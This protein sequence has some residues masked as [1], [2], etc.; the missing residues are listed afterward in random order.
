MWSRMFR[1]VQARIMTAAT[2]DDGMSTAEYAIGT[3]AAAAFGAVL[4]TVV[5]GDSIVSALTGII[6]KALATS[7]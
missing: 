2:G 4:Y 6:D 1:G 3:I 7:V 5:T